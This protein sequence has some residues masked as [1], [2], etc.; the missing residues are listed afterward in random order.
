[1][2]GK[3]FFRLLVIVL[4]VLLA[5]LAMADDE[6]SRLDDGVKLKNRA[7]SAIIVTSILLTALVILAIISK[8]KLHNHKRR[9]FL[10]MIAPV[11]VATL[12]TAGVT[13]YLNQVSLTKGPVHWHADFE[14][15]NCGE[16]ADLLKPS[17]WSNRIGTPVFHEHNDFRIHLEGVVV[18][19]KDISLANFFNVVGGV[20]T[21][22][23]L[24]VLTGKGMVLL[25][26]GDLCQGKPGKVQVFVYKV[27]NP[28]E[29]G[30][31]IYKQEKITDFADHVLSPHSNIPPGDCI[32]MEFDQEK[33][34]T[35]KICT[36]YAAAL[37][38]GELHGR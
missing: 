14:I 12:Y 38:R 11:I 19:K 15:W 34:T 7:M 6:T 13:I 2:I 18:E 8:Q 4:L 1:M 31:W 27:I 24:G 35:D 37:N 32:I 20:L 16:K 5:S 26:D 10:L 28:E 25:Q 23:S 33:E 9:L 30:N 29:H 36:T 22:K 17:G 21:E 3:T